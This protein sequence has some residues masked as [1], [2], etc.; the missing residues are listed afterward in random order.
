[1]PTHTVEVARS[2]SPLRT[3]GTL[4]VYLCGWEK[5]L[6]NHSFGPAIRPHYLFHYIYSGKGTFYANGQMHTLHG[7]QG[8]LIFPGDSTIYTA[9]ENDPWHY[10]W[11]GFDG[12]DVPAILEQCGLSRSAPIFTGKKDA[13]LERRLSNL[14]DVFSGSRVNNYEAVGLLY[15]VFAAM[16]DAVADPGAVRSYADEAAE[17][18]M[19]NY[20]YDI[21][22]ADI[23]Q[24]IGIDR[25]YLYKL[26]EERF[27]CSP[28]TYLIRCRLDAAQKLL[29]R[30][31]AGIAEIALSCGFRDIPGFYKQ[32]GKE[33][34]I[35][36]AKYRNRMQI[37]STKSSSKNEPQKF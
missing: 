13:A 12:S 5:C 26:F 21:R 24:H 7:G 25:T 20:S 6:P 16:S 3:E 15:L 29:T 8:F 35:P 11:F 34:G 19:N 22:I 27:R 28:Q 32:F 4:A 36:P 18:I 31:N 2:H 30:S 1:M 23:A 14:I 10:C 17:F 37:H 33:Y 9:D